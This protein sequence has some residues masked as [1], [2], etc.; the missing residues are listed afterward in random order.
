M[1]VL[2]FSAEEGFVYV[3]EWMMKN[4]QLLEGSL[5][6][7]KYVNLPKGTFMKIQPHRMNFIKLPDP[8]QVLETALKDFAFVTAGDTIMIT[9]QYI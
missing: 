6:V 2:E 5:V 8:K 7:L 3:P 9:Y 1:W 4:L